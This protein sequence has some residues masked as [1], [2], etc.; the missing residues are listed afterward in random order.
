MNLDDIKTQLESLPAATGWPDLITVFERTE[1]VPHPDWELPLL[2]CQAVGGEVRQALPGAAAIACMQISIML[3]DDILD[4]DPR[5]EHLR[6]GTGPTA[7]LALAFQ[8]AAFA[9]IE[10]APISDRQRTE[11]TGS[12][13]RLA[14]ATAMGQQLDVQNLQGEDNYWRVVQAKSTPFYG[15]A[16]QL[17]GI[18][19]CAKSEMSAGLYD[20]GCLIGEIIQIEDDLTDA[21]HSPANADWQQG[22]NNLLILYARTADHSTRETFISLL[23]GVGDPAVLEKAQ[24]ILINSGAV[25]YATYQLINRYQTARHALEALNLPKPA[26]VRDLLLNFADTLVIRLQLSGIELKRESLLEPLEFG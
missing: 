14:L 1:G 5:G 11:I 24:K 4:D 10:Q 23:P 12:L 13:A 8:A 7:N 6:R 3:V 25:S 20:L 18:F 17:G 15:A 22:R 9:L 26:P 19:G 21:F 2:T 16:Y